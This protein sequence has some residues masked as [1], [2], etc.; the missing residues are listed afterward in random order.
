MTSIK[1]ARLPLAP[2]NWAIDPTHSQ[3]G[4][5]IRHL[6]VSKVRGRFAEIDGTLHVAADEGL[7]VTATVALASIDTGNTDRDTHVRGDEFLDVQRR[8]TMTFR[9]TRVEVT[10]DDG[11]QARLDGELTIGDVTRPVSFDVVFGGVE[12]SVVDQRPHAGFEATGHL[13][14]RDFGLSFGPGEAVLGDR[15]TIDLDIQF[16]APDVA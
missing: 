14:R 16:I 15:V 12:T 1:T 13:R 2:G 4:F 7:E 5:A 9:S 3:I 10:D 6:G 8:P 11:E